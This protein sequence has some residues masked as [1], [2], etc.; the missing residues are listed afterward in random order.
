MK[1]NFHLQS[2]PDHNNKYYLLKVDHKNMKLS[3]LFSS[4]ILM[5]VIMPAFT[6]PTK[7]EN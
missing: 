6:I 4:V 3:L 7:L 5:L 1:F 2:K